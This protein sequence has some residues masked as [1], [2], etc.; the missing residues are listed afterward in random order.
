MRYAKPVVENASLRLWLRLWRI[1]VE[2]LRVHK[3]ARSIMGKADGGELADIAGES[4]GQG[5]FQRTR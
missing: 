4:G 1:S 2:G 3:G 5:L